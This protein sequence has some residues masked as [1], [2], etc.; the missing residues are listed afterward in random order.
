MV[1]TKLE[2]PFAHSKA[3]RRCTCQRSPTAQ[4]ESETKKNGIGFKRWRIESPPPQHR[5]RSAVRP[6]R[7]RPL[8][9][10]IRL[11]TGATRWPIAWSPNGRHAQ[12]IRLGAA[13]DAPLSGHT[14][15]H[16]SHRTLSTD[17]WHI[18]PPGVPS[19][20]SCCKPSCRLY[21]KKGQH[22][23]H[24]RAPTRGRKEKITSNP[25]PPPKRKSPPAKMI[26]PPPPHLAPPGVPTPHPLV[27][28][29]L[30]T[31]S[32]PTKHTGLLGTAL[33]QVLKELLLLEIQSH[34]DSK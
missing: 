18:S 20:M 33:T 21:R 17:T 2:T 16:G 13:L 26:Q 28:P 12:Q 1:P 30:P 24:T 23:A 9:D 34:T 29:W 22:N 25:S 31:S 19:I 14:H 4:K 27:S 3:S 6:R 7:A 10:A 15:Q 11:A 5:R 8:I 32:A